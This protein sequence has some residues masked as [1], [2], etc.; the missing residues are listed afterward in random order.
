MGTAR[1]TVQQL[2]NSR[3]GGGG[4][5]GPVRLS[6]EPTIIVQFVL[7]QMTI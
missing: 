2:Y 5:G 3:G 4:G 7:S 6:Q 1:G